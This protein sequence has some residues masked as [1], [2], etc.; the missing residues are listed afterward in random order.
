ML[1]APMKLVVICRMLEK[2]L[3]QV[4]Y[5]K[6]YE[7]RLLDQKHQENGEVYKIL[8]ITFF[9]NKK[10]MAGMVQK[11]DPFQ[12][13]EKWIKLTLKEVHESELNKFMDKMS[14]FK[15]NGFFLNWF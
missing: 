2:P 13:A 15:E 8:K 14:H 5:D 7:I 6:I 10:F 11:Q 9:D 12:K 3:T 1:V 4:D